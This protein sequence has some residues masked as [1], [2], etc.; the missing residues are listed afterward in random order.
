VSFALAPKLDAEG[1]KRHESERDQHSDELPSSALRVPLIP[2]SPEE[3]STYFNVSVR[4]RAWK[5][6]TRYQE[7][8]AD[9]DQQPA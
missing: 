3:T 6:A 4:G 8:E 1:T 7:H 9:H 5:H 2:G